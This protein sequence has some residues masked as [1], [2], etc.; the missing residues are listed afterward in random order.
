MGNAEFEGVNRSRIKVIGSFFAP[1]G[2]Q[3]RCVECRK[4]GWHAKN[5]FL[6]VAGKA[7]TISPAMKNGTKAIYE[8][9]VNSRA[10][11]C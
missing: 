11:T 9:A 8:G 1:W 3:R 7:K 2:M 4:V 6:F 10:D 5:T